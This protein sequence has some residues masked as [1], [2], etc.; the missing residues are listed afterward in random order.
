M[1]R[2]VTLA[3]LL[4]FTVPFGLSISGCHKGT[5]VTYCNGEDSGVVVG[6]TTTITIL[7][8]V[9]GI[10]LSYGQKG[11]APVPGATDCK[12]NVTSPSPYTY[13]T[14]SMTLADINPATGALCAGTW[15][16]NTGGGIADFTTCNPNNL[17][18]VAYITVSSQ[19]VTSNPLPVFIHP[20]VTAVILA[21]PSTNCAT[22]PDPTTSCCPVAANAST[23]GPPYF[24]TACL[25]QGQVGQLSAKVYQGGGTTPADNISCQVGHVTYSPQNS[26]LVTIDQNGVATA[27]APGSTII[28]AIIASTPS[29]AG[30]F[31][32]CPPTNITLVNPGSSTV[33]Q[34]NT[35]PLTVVATDKNGT[36]LTGLSLEYESTTPRTITGS[37]NIDPTYPG[38]AAI[39][40]YCMPPT[41]N[42]AP[43]NQIGLFGNGTPVTSNDVTI[44]SPGSSGTVAYFGSTSSRYLVPVDFTTSTIGAPVQ[45][46]YYPNSMV[47][48]NDGTTIY[49]GSSTELMVVSATGTALTRVDATSP[50]NV[51]A[52]SPDGSTLVI[53]DPVRGV[54]SLEASSGGLITTYGGVGTHAAFSSDSQ[55][56]YITA[57]NQLL[58]YSTFTGWDNITEPSPVLD[59]TVTVPAVGAYFAGV[60]TTARGYCPAT[61]V[62]GTTTTNV[63]Y[64]VADTKAVTTDLVAATNDGKHILGVTAT[65]A[66]PTLN[67]IQVAIPLGACPVNGL[68]FNSTTNTTTLPV[69]TA[70]AITGITPTSD[71]SIAF[72]TYTGTG[73]IL[74]TYA[75]QSSGLGIVGSIKLS[76]TATAP[77][78]AALSTDDTTLYVGTSGD[79]LIHIISRTTLKD[80]G[81]IAPVLPD[82]N[83]NQATPNLIVQR[84]R[85]LTT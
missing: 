58:V 63:F 16:R 49:M 34:N 66:V 54:I 55:T 39:T 14:T 35:Q 12:G 61:T 84:P 18:G 13:A 85:K 30:F 64:P 57:G 67:D 38:T 75:P 11:Q 80:T 21:P 77:V 74:P 68:T 44:T 24:G 25:S 70:T 29:S 33:N 19:G 73:G 17:S 53:S 8:K 69:A 48:S 15:N 27:V 22:D 42:P 1:R 71:S 76:G 2:F 50:G 56:V 82:V 6:Q 26:S 10:S 40:A 43:F 41:C 45:L 4:L 79:N 47:I 36:V 78:A 46:P 72:V 52:V 81:T 3:V 32:V 51:L 62:T 59:A 5:V 31:S 7:P 23:T 65:T 60:T 20:V 9:Y 28:S 83:G 37:S